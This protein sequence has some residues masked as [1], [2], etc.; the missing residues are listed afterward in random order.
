MRALGLMDS[1]AQQLG[2]KRFLD[3]LGICLVELVLFLHPPMRPFGGLI[4]AADLVQFTKHYVAQM[5]R[6]RDVKAIGRKDPRFGIA[7]TVDRGFFWPRKWCPR[8]QGGGL[9]VHRAIDAVRPS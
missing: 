9:A 2:A 4:F 5:R 1:K 3:M 8:G 7:V 6:G